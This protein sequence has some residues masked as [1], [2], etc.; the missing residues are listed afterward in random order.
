MG[1]QINFI[2]RYKYI[3]SYPVYALNPKLQEGKKIK[4]WEPR[5]RLGIYSC[6][7]PRHSRNVSLV[8]NIK[9]ELV[10]TQFLII[11]YNFFE[12]AGLK[13]LFRITPS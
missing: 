6:V 2:S 12:T 10:S 5:V 13:S 7:S 4:K 11:H 9:T 1:S 3:L 8:L